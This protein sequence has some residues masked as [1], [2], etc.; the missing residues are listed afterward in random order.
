[1]NAPKYNTLFELEIIA[2]EVAIANTIMEK[3]REKLH[4][5]IREARGVTDAE[6][7]FAAGLSRGRVQ[8][9]RTSVDP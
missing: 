5:A 3:A 6:M 7:A 4:N 8:Q 9:I 2:Q 1:M